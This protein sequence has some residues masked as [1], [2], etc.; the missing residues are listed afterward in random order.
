MK[1]RKLTPNTKWIIC[2]WDIRGD[3]PELTAKIL[4]RTLKEVHKILAECKKDGYYD[5]VK[6]HIDYFDKVNARRALQGFASFLS[7]GVGGIEYE[8]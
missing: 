1:D 3:S 8:Q 4:K 2:M 5:M 6:N 7:S